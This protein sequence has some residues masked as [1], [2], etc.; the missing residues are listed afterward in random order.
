V[1]FFSDIFAG[2]FRGWKSFLPDLNFRD[3]GHAN[4]MFA[5][6]RHALAP[7][8][9]FLY[10]VDIQLNPRAMTK[11]FTANEQIKLNMLVKRAQLPGYDLNLDE[12]NAYNRHTYAYKRMKYNPIEIEFHDDNSDIVN[13]FWASYY[14]YMIQ[15]S[16]L[17]AQMFAADK[18]M[19]RENHSFGIDNTQYA[20]L[21]SE[22]LFTINLYCMNRK[23]FVGMKLINPR[24]DQFKHDTVS[25]EGSST[26]KSTMRVVYEAVEYTQGKVSFGNPRGFATLKY[27][28]EP[29]PL[30]LP[31]KSIT[32]ILGEGGLLDTG[33]GIFD[34]IKEGNFLSAALKGG[35]IVKSIQQGGLKSALKS[36]AAGLVTGVLSGRNP[37]D[38]IAPSVTGL[39]A[40][41]A[42]SVQQT[43][44]PGTTT[45]GSVPRISNVDNTG[46]YSVNQSAV[47]SQAGQNLTGAIANLGPVRA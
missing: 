41:T 43:L 13:G 1:S 35:S 9:N 4:K 23:R 45:Q 21:G 24:I 44:S 20:K 39:F 38:S 37:L 40:P 12:K 6:E 32:G 17:G 36:E 11:G 30:K 18:H 22:G 5:S 33:A 10:Y 31:G 2:Q 42:N 7:K 47:A 3:F 29:S 15:D 26:L 46:T 14:A 27:D 25:S 28:Q 16:T 19:K 34:D 8:F